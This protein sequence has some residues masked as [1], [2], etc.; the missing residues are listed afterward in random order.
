MSSPGLFANDSYLDK[1]DD[2]I[3]NFMNNLKRR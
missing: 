2:V 1:Q 3:H